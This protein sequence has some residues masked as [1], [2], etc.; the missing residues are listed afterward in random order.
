MNI[1]VQQAA[2]ILRVALGLK[3]FCKESEFK[4]FVVRGAE[5]VLLYV[6]GA[7]EE[8]LLKNNNSNNKKKILIRSS[9]CLESGNQY[10]P[11]TEWALWQ[12]ESVTKWQVSGGSSVGRHTPLGQADTTNRARSDRS[13]PHSVA[14]SLAE[15]GFLSTGTHLSLVLA[16]LSIIGAPRGFCSQAQKRGWMSYVKHATQNQCFITQPSNIYS[17]LLFR[18]GSLTKVHYVN[19][20]WLAW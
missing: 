15:T 1:R 6:T 4:H 18:L 9:L 10:L 13:C 2:M 7:S 5:L 17:A 12:L 19:K 8:L 16:V 11:I 3:L 20:L 14:L